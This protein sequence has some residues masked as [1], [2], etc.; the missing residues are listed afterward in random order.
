MGQYNRSK[1][2]FRE[3]LYS[4]YKTMVNI[5][6][7][8]HGCLWIGEQVTDYQLCSGDIDT[9]PDLSEQDTVRYEYNQWAYT[10]SQ[11]SCTIFAAAWMLSD[12]K[13]YKF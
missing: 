11:V 3:L 13:N 5:L 2:D 6:D 9:L 12:L 1:E 8:E 4:K 7:I 10:W